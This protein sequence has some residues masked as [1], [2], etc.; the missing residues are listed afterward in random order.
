MIDTDNKQKAARLI[1]AVADSSFE[2]GTVQTNRSTAVQNLKSKPA[3]WG[4]HP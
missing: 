2:D 4:L 3:T 1:T